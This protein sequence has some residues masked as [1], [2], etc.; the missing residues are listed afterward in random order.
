M[1]GDDDGCVS[2]RTPPPPRVK[3]S[4]IYTATTAQSSPSG[5]ENI[6]QPLAVQVEARRMDSQDDSAERHVYSGSDRIL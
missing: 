6:Q 4:D 3:K 1:G 2:E 5:D